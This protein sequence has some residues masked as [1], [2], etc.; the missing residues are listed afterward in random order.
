MTATN[1][2]LEWAGWR[3]VALLSLTLALA[4]P[5]AFAQ[6]HDTAA[7]AGAQALTFSRHVD[8][9]FTLAN[10]NTAMANA[11]TTVQKCD[12]T[13]DANQDVACQVTMSVAG[14][15]VGNFGATGDGGDMILTDAAMNTLINSGTADVM[16]VT[17]IGRC[18]GAGPG[19]GL[20]IIGCGNIGRRGIVSVNTLPGSQLGVEITHEFLHN[21]GHEHRGCQTAACTAA[22]RVGTQVC[23]CCTGA[24]TGTCNEGA[25]T[26][27]AILNPILSLSSNLLNQAECAS[28]HNGP[29]FTAADNGPIVDLPPVLSGCPASR[30]VECTSPTGTTGANAEI[31]GFIA[32]V[33]AAEPPSESCEPAPTLAN[34]APASFPRGTTVFTVTATGVDFQNKSSS[35]QLTVNVVDTTAPSITCPAPVSV[36]CSQAG[37]TPAS[38]PTIAA[39]LAGASATDVCDPAPVVKNNAPTFFPVG[40]TTVS[41]NAKDADGNTS[42]CTDTVSVADMTAPVVTAL[43]ANPS[44]LWP[45]DHKLRAI[46]IVAS[47]TD[48]CDTAPKCRITSVTSNEPV[49][50]PGSG[51]T[52][53]DWVITEPGPS[54][55]PAT[56]G[57]LLRSE[58][59]GTGTGRVYTI[60]VSCSDAAGNTTA[61]QTKVTV[62]HDQGG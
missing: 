23:G 49:L 58:R 62:S 6:H 15:A 60:N 33:T 40:T 47:A 18:G 45:P 11:S 10:A 21:Q 9:A 55:S 56:L 17:A 48:I 5:P 25:M 35:C 32:G 29:S 31:T 36:E 1:R 57:V 61:A 43:A 14:G 44:T 42:Q 46:S 51:N 41:F 8:T 19:P 54:V 3:V 37:G 27:G 28:L 24:G 4:A 16:V 22:G 20:T 53:P 12:S 38:N 50:G 2:I 13:P 30:N 39:A 26:A 7:R 59:S 34:N 52:D